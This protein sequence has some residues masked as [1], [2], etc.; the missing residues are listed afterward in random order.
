MLGLVCVCVCVCVCGCGC[1]CGCGCFLFMAS[2]LICLL[3][4]YG[5]C[6]V[7]ATGD[8]VMRAYG[9]GDRVEGDGVKCCRHIMTAFSCRLPSTF[10]QTPIDLCTSPTQLPPR[11]YGRGK[12]ERVWLQGSGAKYGKRT[13][14]LV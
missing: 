13:L 4:A 10:Q 3:C 2:I 11:R 7:G 9:D 12:R 8:G 1:G 14:R 6:A 5:S